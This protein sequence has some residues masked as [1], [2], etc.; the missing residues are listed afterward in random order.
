MDAASYLSRFAKLMR[1]ILDQSKHN[2]L[3]LG[4]VMETLRM[5][6][7]IEAF[8]FNNEFTYTFNVEDN[9]SLLDAMIP[10]MLLQ[11]FVE[12][13]IL[14]GLMPRTGEK[15]LT[16]GCKLVNK[17]V[18]ITIDDNGVGR[19]NHSAKAGHDSQGEKLTA[20]MLETLQQL[21]N[22]KAAIN[23]T[24]KMENGVAAGTQVQ[25]TFTVN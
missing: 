21:K 7:E 16:I 18:L 6:V 3:P 10:P 1:R 5:Y 20:G 12:N 23:I 17:Q 22:I 4:E 2:F 24:D 9:D 25:L 8:R 11:P 14:H 13:A 15:R 19:G